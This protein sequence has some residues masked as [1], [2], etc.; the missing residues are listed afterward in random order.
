M[1][2]GNIYHTVERVSY[3]KRSRYTLFSTVPL[4]M[5]YGT[6]TYGLLKKKRNEL[7]W[8]SLY[9]KLFG[10]QKKRLSYKSLPSDHCSAE[11][12]PW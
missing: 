4:D 8:L 5:F 7:T 1:A 2:S 12:S 3:M 11:K 10:S 9:L 6:A